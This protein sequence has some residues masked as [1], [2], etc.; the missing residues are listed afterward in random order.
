MTVE[1][2]Y[3]VASFASWPNFWCHF[4]IKI[5]VTL[6]LNSSWPPQ[7]PR[8]YGRRWKFFFFI[9]FLVNSLKTCAFVVHQII[10]K[11]LK[12]HQIPETLFDS[13]INHDDCNVFLA[14]HSRQV[15]LDL[16]ASEANSWVSFFWM[17]IR[18]KVLARESLLDPLKTLHWR[19][20]DFQFGKSI[21]TSSRSYL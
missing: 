18:R 12:L 17:N 16:S 7:K 19:R 8:K 14:E 3:I 5:P 11:T 2:R 13:T 9:S 6:P 21:F 20:I 15:R 4:P 10:P 1:V